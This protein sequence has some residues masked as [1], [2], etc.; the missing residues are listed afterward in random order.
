MWAL[1]DIVPDCIRRPSKN[2]A[3]SSSSFRSVRM[4]GRTYTHAVQILPLLATRQA[5]LT[6]NAPAMIHAMPQAV[7]RWQGLA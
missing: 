4:F 2:S 7:G 1:T 5:G 6:D 3:R